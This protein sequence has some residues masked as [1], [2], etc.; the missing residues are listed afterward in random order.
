MRFMCKSGLIE[1]YLFKRL[2]RFRSDLFIGADYAE[3]LLPSV[4]VLFHLFRAH[5]Q[6]KRERGRAR[7]RM[8]QINYGDRREARNRKNGKK[9]RAVF[10]F[11]LLIKI[12]YLDLL[13]WER[14]AEVYILLRRERKGGR[15]REKI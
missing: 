11:L 2:T 3:L 5:I 12:V 13:H 8:R 14:I 9:Q 10:V 7:E 4:D 6:S 15:G 1:F